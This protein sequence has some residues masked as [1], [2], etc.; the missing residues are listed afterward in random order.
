MFNIKKIIEEQ[1]S[2]DPCGFNN[3][4]AMDKFQII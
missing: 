4:N 3:R 2:V 1:S